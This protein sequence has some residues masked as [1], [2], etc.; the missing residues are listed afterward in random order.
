MQHLIELNKQLYFN[1]VKN[2]NSNREI[3]D[4]KALGGICSLVEISVCG[5]QISV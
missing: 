3:K 5:V 2:S 1:E 4:C